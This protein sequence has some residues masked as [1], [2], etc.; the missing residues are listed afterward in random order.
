LYAIPKDNVTTGVVD[1]IKV[2][3]NPKVQFY[4]SQML[5]VHKD[6]SKKKLAPPRMVIDLSDEKIEPYQGVRVNTGYIVKVKPITYKYT[7]E[8]DKPKA[9]EE[10]LQSQPEFII[11]PM[12]VSDHKKT[13]IPSVYARDPED[14]GLL[15]INFTVGAEVP[16]FKNKPLQITLDAFL[17]E[18]PAR[19]AR[20]VEKAP[21]GVDVIEKRDV[22]LFKPKDNKMGR[23]VK[24]PKTKY[25]A[26][27]FQVTKNDCLL[28][29][30]FDGTKKPIERIDNQ[31]I[32]FSKVPV[33]F[34]SRKREWCNKELV[35]Y[36]GMWCPPAHY[37]KEQLERMAKEKKQQPETQLEPTIIE[38]STVDKNTHGVSFLKAR[39]T[40][41]SVDAEDKDD[42]NDLKILNGAFADVPYY[43]ELVKK[44]RQILAS[45]NG[46][47]VGAV[48]VNDIIEERPELSFDWLMTVYDYH[49]VLDKNETKYLHADKITEQ[50]VFEERQADLNAYSVNLK[51][52]LKLFALL[53]CSDRFTRAQIEQLSKECGLSDNG[54]GNNNSNGGNKRAREDDATNN[55]Q[56]QQ[57]EVKD[58]ENKPV[59]HSNKIQKTE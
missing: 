13:I 49:R 28:V 41:Y 40:L 3:D 9:N 11:L 24:N 18:K 47:S 25:F 19:I 7:I 53:Y 6:A 36:A 59:E 27:S 21:N 58:E 46:L 8:N 29:E 32:E 17:V 16:D 12:I 39:I 48:T 26:D 35:T 33:F 1:L 23:C 30:T 44:Y 51:K 43:D 22:V 34:S 54:V 2:Q 57:E 50:Q 20:I 45:L 55:G 38:N 37:T 4:H 42:L 52:G 15:T 14:S 5:P 10:T 56:Q 31:Y